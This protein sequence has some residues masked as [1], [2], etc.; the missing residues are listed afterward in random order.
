MGW[1]EGQ[2][3]PR[4]PMIRT[5]GLLLVSGVEVEGVGWGSGCEVMVAVRARDRCRW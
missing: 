3:V 5:E 2:G 4:P 1:D